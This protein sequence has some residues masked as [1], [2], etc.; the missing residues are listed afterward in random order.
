MKVV[1]GSA[2][3]DWCVPSSSLQYLQSTAQYG[4]LRNTTAQYCAVPYNQALEMRIPYCIYMHYSAP[5]ANFILQTLYLIFGQKFLEENIVFLIQFWSKIIESV[6]K[7]QSSNQSQHYFTK[8]IFCH[9]RISSSSIFH[10]VLRA[11]L[12]KQLKLQL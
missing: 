9:K 8:S 1:C 11:V 3:L 7:A 6:I 2:P 5:A 12:M 10:D 4:T